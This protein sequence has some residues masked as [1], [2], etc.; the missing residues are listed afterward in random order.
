MNSFVAFKT[1]TQWSELKNELK[2]F[3]RTINEKLLFLIF[4]CLLLIV[5]L[6]I[7]NLREN[8]VIFLPCDFLRHTKSNRTKL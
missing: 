6:A 5:S 4:L 2:T 1:Q 7:R 8:P 3:L